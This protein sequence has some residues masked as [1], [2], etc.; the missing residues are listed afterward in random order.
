[1]DEIKKEKMAM[2]TKV[3]WQKRQK[4]DEKQVDKKSKMT[5]H[6]AID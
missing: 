1:M 6:K 4:V 5:K 2:L 3:Y